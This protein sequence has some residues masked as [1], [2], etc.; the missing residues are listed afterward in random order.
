MN[1]TDSFWWKSGCF[2]LLSQAQVLLLSSEKANHFCKQCSISIKDLLEPFSS[3]YTEGI[4]LII[5]NNFIYTL[6]TQLPFFIHSYVFIF[7]L[8]CTQRMQTKKFKNYI[9]LV[10][11]ILLFRN[12]KNLNLFVS[13]ISKHF[14]PLLS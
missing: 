7:S 5:F 4:S 14:T 12:W 11:L 3:L 1:P 6:H 8:K 10:F 13:F 2:S 9:N